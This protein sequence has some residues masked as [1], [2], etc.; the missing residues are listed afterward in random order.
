MVSGG[1]GWGYHA[2]ANA[3]RGRRS[4]SPDGLREALESF[5]ATKM[6]SGIAFAHG[7]L[8]GYT[9]T[10]L[11]RTIEATTAATLRQLFKRCKKSCF[12]PAFSAVRQRGTEHE[13]VRLRS[14]ASKQAR[15]AGVVGAACWQ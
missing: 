10:S 2:H 8:A 15:T 6:H 14:E 12:P 1:R 3:R 5:A 13:S 11:L 7:G 9:A 4:C